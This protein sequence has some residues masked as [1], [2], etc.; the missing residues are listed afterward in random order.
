MSKRKRRYVQGVPHLLRQRG[1][2]KVW[3]GYIPDR[4]EVSL[5]TADAAEAQRRLVALAADGGGA[6]GVAAPAVAPKLTELAMLFAEYC[7][8]PRH[9]TKTGTSYALRV[10]RF[11]EWAEDRRVTTTDQVT[12]AV[13]ADYVRARTAGD[14]TAATINRDVI[15]VRLMFAFGA[16]EGHL[17]DDPFEKRAFRKLKLKEPRGKPNALTLSPAQ[18]DTF[19]ERAD[20]MSPATYAA[21]FR[22]TAGS[23]L[24]IDEARHLEDHDI[25]TGRRVLTVTPKKGWTTKGY[26]YRDV[27]IS[28]RT[29]A[30]GRTFIRLR[31]KVALDDK[32][33]WKEIHRVREGTDLPKFSMHDLRRAWASAMHANGATLKQISVWLGHA[34]IA[35]TERYIRVFGGETTGH[36]F[37]PR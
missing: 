13:M 11:V 6:E 18:V 7:K 8:P 15:A 5:G 34:D 12:F 30:A 3:T 35:T 2:G 10:A 17:G 21:L 33:V 9:T 37:L 20:A 28:E 29:A 4:G 31:D 1:R 23:G 14:V 36:E 24:R 32:S 19:L 22:V 16:R 25:D 27:P 26:R